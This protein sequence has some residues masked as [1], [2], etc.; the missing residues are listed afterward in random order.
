MRGLITYSC[1]LLQSFAL[2]HTS[3]KTHQKWVPSILQL[4]SF[5]WSHNPRLTTHTDECNMFDVK[6]QKF[7]WFHITNEGY[8]GT[9]DCCEQPWNRA[10]QTWH[11]T[12]SCPRWWPAGL[13]TWIFLENFQTARIPTNIFP[14]LS[15]SHVVQ[16]RCPFTYWQQH[17]ASLDVFL[18]ICWSFIS[19]WH[20]KGTKSS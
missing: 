9:E 10:L 13:V 5:Y 20:M 16:E 17:A 12:F 14:F 15:S 18:K 11:T 3:C 8:A 2:C 1:I 6:L 7:H 19:G 4:R